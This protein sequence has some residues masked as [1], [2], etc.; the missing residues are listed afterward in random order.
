MSRTARRGLAVLRPVLEQVPKSERSSGEPED[1][2][3]GA[4][5]ASHEP[6]LPDPRAQSLGR[7]RIERAAVARS[8][9][10]PMGAA[11]AW[12]IW[13][14]VLPGNPVPV[15]LAGALVPLYL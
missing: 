15:L 13:A 8:E 9:E 3:S 1:S 14:A 4:G 11:C 5:V 7:R 2:E 6:L 10:N 12:T